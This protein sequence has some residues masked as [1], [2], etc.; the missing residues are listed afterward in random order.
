LPNATEELLR[1]DTS[2]QM[3]MRLIR[4]D[5]DLGSSKIPAGSIVALGY[6]AANRDP[7]IFRDPDR[8]DL[9]RNPTH[10][11]F[12]A[13]AYY[14]LGNALARTEIQAALG[15]LFRRLPGIRA[16][17]EHFVQRWTARLRG[18]LELRVAWD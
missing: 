11:A 10:L 8:L 4:E 13:G 1:Y 6:G 17:G 12:S 16:E 2:V 18:P 5:I 7:E 3:S 9:D 15:V 14:C